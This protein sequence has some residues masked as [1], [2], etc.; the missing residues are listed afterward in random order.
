[1]ICASLRPEMRAAAIYSS[2][3]TASVTLRSTRETPAE[4]I[5]PSVTMAGSMA[6]PNTAS[7]ASMISMV[8]KD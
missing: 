3:R 5:T 7:T 2:S 1:M 8:G 6:W 4:P